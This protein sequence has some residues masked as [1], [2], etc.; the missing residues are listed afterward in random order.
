[1][2]IVSIRVLTDYRGGNQEAG[3]ATP[4]QCLIYFGSEKRGTANKL[5]LGRQKK[6]MMF[7]RIA[8]F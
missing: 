5:P 3:K 7:Q 1:M 4:V 6:D 8:M 2:G